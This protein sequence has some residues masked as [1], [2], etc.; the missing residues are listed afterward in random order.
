MTEKNE[1]GIKLPENPRY[2]VARVGLHHFEEPPVSG[3]RGSGTIFFGGC[4]LRCVFCQNYE[5]SH[6]AK[7]IN[8]SQD[9][10]IGLMLY[11]QSQGAHNINLVTPSH[12]VKCLAVTLAKAK[13]LLKIPVV[14]NTS[15]YERAEHLRLLEGLADVYLPDFK[16]CDEALAVRF[17]QAKNY[18]ERASGALEEML[19]QRPECVFENGLITKGVIVRHL[20]LPGSACDSKRVLDY[21]AGVDANL[22]ISLMSQYFPPRNLPPPLNRRLTKREYNGVADYMIEKGFVN[23]WTQELSSATREYVPNFDLDELE[24]ILKEIK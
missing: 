10:L 21:L 12:Y 20:V 9:E 15:A 6:R 2:I 11:L 24:R 1:K 7:G 16:Y 17:S 4:A 5:I 23:G 3:E 18:F 22:Y 8:V 14:Y 19:R 13:P